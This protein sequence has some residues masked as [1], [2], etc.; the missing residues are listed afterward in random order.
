MWPTDLQQLIII[1]KQK[2]GLIYLE[3][4]KMASRI[5]LKNSETLASVKIWKSQKSKFWAQMYVLASCQYCRLLDL[6]ALW[7]FSVAFIVF[8]C[9]GSQL[10]QQ[11]FYGPFQKREIK[12]ITPRN[13]TLS[14]PNLFLWKVKLPNS[15]LLS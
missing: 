8:L 10:M 6:A 7:K 12:K 5:T 3:I 14:I 9:T 13:L 11:R 1:Q 2:F 15:N 4:P